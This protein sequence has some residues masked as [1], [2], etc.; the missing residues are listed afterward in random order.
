MKANM[1]AR[2]NPIIASISVV[3]II[4]EWYLDL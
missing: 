1:T 3:I 4:M 2:D